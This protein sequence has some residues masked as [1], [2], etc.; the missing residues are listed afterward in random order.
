MVAFYAGICIFCIKCNHLRWKSKEGRRKGIDG[1][2]GKR[3]RWRTVLPQAFIIE[4]ST[5]S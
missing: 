3:N 5:N 1:I 4:N 2:K